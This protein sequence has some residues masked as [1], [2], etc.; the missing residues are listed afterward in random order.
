MKILG[1]C[2]DALSTV[3]I[4]FAAYGITE[5]YLWAAIISGAYIGYFA[6]P[7]FFEE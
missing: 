4:T 7:S 1:Y 5:S 3:A 2:L 6:E